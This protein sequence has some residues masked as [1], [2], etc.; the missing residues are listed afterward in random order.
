MNEKIKIKGFRL[1]F[2]LLL[3]AAFWAF[4]YYPCISLD[5]VALPEK[6]RKNDFKEV[7]I[8]YG[9]GVCTTCSTGKYVYALRERENIL[10]ILPGHFNK[11]DMENFNNVFMLKGRVIKG[12]E[13]VLKLVK[14]IN[15]CKELDMWK[16]NFHIKLEKDG[17]IALVKGI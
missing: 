3:I 10:V 2:I 1:L 9:S 13:D 6:I 4:N 5:F 12:D 17:K 16:A 15:R 7:L 14:R 11:Y 8:L